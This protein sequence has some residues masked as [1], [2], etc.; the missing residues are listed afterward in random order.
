MPDFVRSARQTRG[1]LCLAIAVCAWVA[2][3]ASWRGT[4]PVIENQFVV[5]YN[6][7]A[8]SMAAP[9][10]ELQPQAPA[11]MMGPGRKL[12]PPSS[13]DRWPITLAEAVRMGVE[14]NAVIRQNAQFMSPNNPILQ[15]PDSVPS[16]FDPGIQNAGVLFGSRG[17]D[18]ALSDFDPRLTSSIKWNRSENAQNSLLLPPPGNVLASEGALFQTRFDQQLLSGGVFGLYNTWN[19]AQTNQPA[20]LFASTYTGQLGFDFRQPLWAGAGREFSAIA[21]PLDQRARGFSYVNQGIVIA[22]INKRLSEIDLQENL[23]NLVREIGDL[24]WDLYQNYQDYESETQASK[25]AKELWD[26]AVGRANIDPGIEEAQAEDAYYESK[27]REELALSNL[28]L[29]EARL[30]RLVGL[31]LDDSRMLYP[32]DE[33]R[34]E[35]LSLSRATC[36]YEALVN[37]IELS[38]QKLNVQSLELQ[39]IAARKLVAPK[40]D[41]VAG[42]GLNGFGDK[43]YS[44]TTSDS[45]NT[46]Q[47]FNSA[48]TTMF[49]GK[50]TSWDFGFQYQ[51]PLW[52]RQE[53]AQVRQLELRIAKGRA[54]L[55]MQEDEIA[56][57]LNTVLMTIER[58]HSMSKLT[59]RRLQ[60][61]RRRVIAAEADYEAGNKSNDLALRAISSLTLAQAAYSKSITEYNKSLRD[62][63]FRTGRIL[64]ADGIS[65][66]GTDGLPMVPDER[67][68][69]FFYLANPDLT[70]AADGAETA[71]ETDESEI[72]PTPSRSVSGADDLDEDLPESMDNSVEDE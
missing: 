39:L 53:K 60:A 37:R 70:P 71:D 20:Q 68:N 48:V 24:Y 72:P 9:N 42:Y 19:Y 13:E 65:L 5:H 26:R 51:L 46:R 56:H 41:F 21:G 59:R 55:A 15:G 8:E 40:L 61:A 52:L 22:H 30:R 50:E 6:R 17:V 44:T 35:E 66:L 18:A 43:F 16:V 63:L 64:P 3:C 69:D 29:T 36:L 67:P 2:G 31:S 38:R 12:V 45:M 25:I 33:P 4:E 10:P 47:G 58:A 14:N 32:C 11:P 49:S 34:E 28:F 54:A 7:L 62:L 27:S 1:I 57:E 23:Q